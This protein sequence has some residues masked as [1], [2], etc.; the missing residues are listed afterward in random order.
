MVKRRNVISQDGGSGYKTY[1]FKESTT[2]CPIDRKGQ[3]RQGVIYPR[4]ADVSCT[5]DVRESM[6]SPMEA[7]VVRFRDRPTIKRI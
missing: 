1:I 5:R 7:P 6:G 2:R 3:G 4:V